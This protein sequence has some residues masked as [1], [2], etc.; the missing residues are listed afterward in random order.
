MSVHS[1]PNHDEEDMSDEDGRRR[2]D[3]DGM[4]NNDDDDGDDKEDLGTYVCPIFIAFF[5]WRTV[6][7]RLA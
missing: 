7:E 4:N 1:N 5:F 2:G 3:K 6:S